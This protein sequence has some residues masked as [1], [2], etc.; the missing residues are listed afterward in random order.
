LET[1]RRDKGSLPAV[2]RDTL[3]ETSNK[4]NIK[5]LASMANRHPSFNE[6]L[7]NRRTSCNDMREMLRQ[8][9]PT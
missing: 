7:L 4:K 8:I 2:M 9:E 6:F 1:L 3:S 5:L